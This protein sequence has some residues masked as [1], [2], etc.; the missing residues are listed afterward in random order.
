MVR[1]RRVCSTLSPLAGLGGGES[2]AASPGLLL[3][4][5]AWA[6]ALSCQR[7]GSFT[8]QM[9]ECRRMEGAVKS[10]VFAWSWSPWGLTDSCRKM[11]I[12][13]ALAWRTAQLPVGSKGL[14]LPTRGHSW[15]LYPTYCDK[16]ADRAKNKDLPIS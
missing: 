9:E 1:T 10:T 6:F 15:T 11:G 8:Q 14:K 16:W 4:L 7:S 13:G 5:L 3:S 2:R 12:P